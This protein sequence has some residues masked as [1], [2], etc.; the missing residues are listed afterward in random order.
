MLMMSE[1]M[2]SASPDINAP[3]DVFLIFSRQLCDCALAV[4]AQGACQK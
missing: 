3:L 4:L 1:P 2:R